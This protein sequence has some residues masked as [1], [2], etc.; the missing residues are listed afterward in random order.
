MAEVKDA[1]TKAE[2]RQELAKTLAKDAGAVA[3]KAREKIDELLD[4]DPELYTGDT[5]L[6][7]FLEEDEVGERYSHFNTMVKILLTKD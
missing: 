5:P 3:R 6:F 2:K 7:D 1:A 4:L